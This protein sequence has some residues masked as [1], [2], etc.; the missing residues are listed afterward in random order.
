MAVEFWVGVRCALEPEMGH[1]CTMRVCKDMGLAKGSV[2]HH[3][4]HRWGAVMKASLGSEAARYRRLKWDG[5]RISTN[6]C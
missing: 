4:D 2:T 6:I 5:P 1:P 3:D